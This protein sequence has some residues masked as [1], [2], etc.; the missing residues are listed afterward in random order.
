[1]PCITN[2][3]ESY[4]TSV[5]NSVTDDGPGVSDAK[6]IFEVFF[7]TKPHGTGLGLAVVA[8]IVRDHGG[9]VWVDNAP[10]RGARVTFN[11]PVFAASALS[12]RETA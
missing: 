9:A 2:L 11:V 12:D 7:T 3:Y 6:R 8:R 5:Y 4:H 1:M 10:G